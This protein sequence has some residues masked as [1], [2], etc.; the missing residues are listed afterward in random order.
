[1]LTFLMELMEIKGKATT[2][3]LKC[4]DNSILVEE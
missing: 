3:V 1:M 2:L 4:S